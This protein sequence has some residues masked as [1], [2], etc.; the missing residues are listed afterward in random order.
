MTRRWWA[1]AVPLV[2]ALAACGG[3]GGDAASAPTSTTTTTSTTSTTTTTTAA[4]A[5]TPDGASTCWTAPVTPGRGPIELED[6]TEGAG[7]V[8]PLLGMFGHAVAIGDVDRDGWPDLFV[9]TFGD[10]PDAQ[11]RR[12][13]AEGPSPDRLLLGGPDGFRVD[14]TFP[15]ERARSSGATF[16]DLDGDGWPELVVARNATAAGGVAGVPTTVYANEG[17]RLTAATELLPRVRARAVA[18]LDVEGDGDLDLYIAAD[19]YGRAAG[20]L[21]RNDGELRF[22]DVT[23]EAGLDDVQGLA[24]S[25]ADLDGDGRPDLYVGGADRVFLNDGDGRFRT[26]AEGDFEFPDRGEEDDVAGVAVGDLDR[27]GRP[28]LVVG[29]HYNSTLDDGRRIPVRVFLQRDDASFDDVT[30]ASGMPD[31]ATKAPHVEV[32]DVD[33]D[34][35]PDVVATASADGRP[36]VLRNGGVDDDSVPQFEATPGDVDESYWVTG[37]TFDADRDGRL[38][39]LALDYEPER[40]TLLLGNAS[41]VGHWLEVEAGPDPARSMG[42]LVEVFEAGGL[43][44]P[45]RRLAR[46]EI[47]AGTGYAAGAEPVARAGLGD[48]DRVDVRVTRPWDGGATEVRGVAA[49]QRVRIGGDC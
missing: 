11:Y 21:L 27:D 14:E 36:L 28:D 34:G 35:W 24:A 16:A 10:R 40:P 13:G 1:V 29:Q 39:V 25:A 30:D 42:T 32:V 37:A 44:D 15:A 6:R 9:G 2:L 19:R 45:A 23:E 49:D 26:A 18:V 22:E 17:G 12:R 4:P 38:D 43:G 3:D 48:V 41:D 33:N 47:T 7:L 20:S 5:T 46:G 8:E 31:L